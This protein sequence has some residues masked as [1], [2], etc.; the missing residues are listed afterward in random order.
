M[1][2]IGKI[3]IPIFIFLFTLSGLLFVWTKFRPV[4]EEGF[5]TIGH[6]WTVISEGNKDI[7]PGVSDLFYFNSGAI[8]RLKISNKF[9]LVSDNIYFVNK[10]GIRDDKDVVETKKSH[11]LFSGC[12]FV[13]GASVNYEDTF[14]KILR[15]SLPNVNVRNL[16][17]TGGGLHSSLRYMELVPLRDFVHEEKGIYAYVYITDHFSRWIRDLSYLRWAWAKTP[18]YGMVDGKIQYT[19]KLDEQFDYNKYHFFKKIG[20]ELPEIGPFS[21]TDKGTDYKKGEI[22]LEGI[23]ELKKNYL[24]MYPQGR[25]IWLIHPMAGVNKM[26]EVLIEMAARKK[27]IEVMFA[28]RDFKAHLKKNNLKSEDFILP[29]DR[30]PTGKLNAWFASWIVE[31]LKRPVER[32]DA[33]LDLKGGSRLPEAPMTKKQSIKNRKR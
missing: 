26:Q 33:V 8:K 2:L 7:Y 15:E 22:F 27:G 20:I 4:Q 24:K 25:F 5:S 28:N 32:G 6:D 3:F 16:G 17:F 21:Y 12:S 23:A 29:W 31:N 9:G 30:H 13:F 11:L 19:G 18:T 14:P 1:R 10:F